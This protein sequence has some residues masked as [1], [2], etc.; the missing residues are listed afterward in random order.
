MELFSSEPN[1]Q[2]QY[3]TYLRQ[4]QSQ[5]EPITIGSGILEIMIDDVIIKNEAQARGIEVTDDEIEKYFQTLFGY[6]PNGTPTPTNTKEIAQTSTLSATQLAIVTLT[7][8]ATKLPTNTPDTDVIPTTQPPETN[9]T[10]T[11]TPEPYSYNEYQEDLQ[12]YF[13]SLQS[14]PI[15]VSEE[16]LRKILQS[17]LFREKL[18]DAITEGLPGEEE[19]VWARHILVEDEVTALEILERFYIGEDW[20]ALALEFSTDTSNADRGGD[21]GWFN[22]STMVPAFSEVAFNTPIGS[23]SD[24]VQTDF[25][26]HL[27]QVI[28]HEMRP[29]SQNEYLQ[30]KENEFQ[31]WLSQ[32]RFTVEIEIMDYWLDRIP[33]KP[34]IPAQLLLP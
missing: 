14:N 7:P 26:W 2:S 24:P 19:R 27:I 1:I 31:G 33:E 32:I 25:G 13:E 20:A 29:L 5:L 11:I 6:F 10:P 22:E 4:I 21:L 34:A 23:V 30:L 3:Q 8:T 17:Q 9:P 28:G 15:R 16:D 18:R 12:A